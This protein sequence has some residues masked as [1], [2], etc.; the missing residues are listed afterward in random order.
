MG[1]VYYGVNPRLETE[2]A[3]KIL[4]LA[5]AQQQQSLVERFLREARIAAK[6]KSPHIAA[7]YDVN[8]EYGL[9]YIQMEYVDGASAGSYLRQV[10]AASG[11]GLPETTALD[12]CIA[13]CEGLSAA[14]AEGIIHR[15]IKP[16]NIMIPRRK[17]GVESGNLEFRAAKLL[18]LGLARSLQS[19]HGRDLTLNDTGMGTP[20]Y[21][22]PEQAQDAKSVR[23]PADVYSLGATLYALLSGHA[24]FR[25]DTPL[26]VA[27]AT[28]SKPHEP[29]GNSRHDLHPKTVE[30]IECCL[31]K[32]PLNRPANAAM[33]LADLRLCRMVVGEPAVTLVTPKPAAPPIAAPAPGRA[34]AVVK[35]PI[36]IPVA[37]AAAPA[38]AVRTAQARSPAAAVRTRAATESKET[39][40]I[41][42]LAV[43]LAAMFVMFVAA[44]VVVVLYLALTSKS[45]GNTAE[46]VFSS[47]EGTIV[48]VKVSPESRVHVGDELVTVMDDTFNG[49]T[50]T[51]RKEGIVQEVFVKQGD[52]V[53]VTTPLVSVRPSD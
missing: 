3:I 32:D 14:H 6:V 31:Q 41:N 15:D 4:P 53:G 28:L 8:M 51:A 13:A 2:V 18:D 21:M 7:V 24:P 9:F 36:P 50:I 46:Q 11:R 30:L 38:G 19:F 33:L 47:F 29:I 44:A 40:G 20:G 48:E 45:G 37:R 34:A 26:N 17:R 25:G 49:H 22:P 42:W 23:E 12:I 10:F 35:A 52:T 43:G 39:S 5:N 1:A 16:D 27:M